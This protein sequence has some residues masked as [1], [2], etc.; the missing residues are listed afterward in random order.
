M[1]TSLLSLTPEEKIQRY[2]EL[3]AT[4]TSASY[5]AYEP[6]APVDASTEPAKQ[7]NFSSMIPPTM[8]VNALLHSTPI[9]KGTVEVKEEDSPLSI[10]N[11]FGSKSKPSMVPHKMVK[12]SPSLQGAMDYLTKDKGL[13]KHVAAGIVGN[14]YYESGLD[15]KIKQQNGGPGRGI[16]QWTDGDRWD[17]FKKWAKDAGRDPLDLQTQLDYVL[18]EPGWGD[19]AL[20]DTL[21]AKDAD[22]ATMI[23]GKSYERPKESKA[24]W[25]YRKRVANSLLVHQNY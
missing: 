9:P 3:T 14:L 17:G 24:N 1:Y 2:K 15:P 20:R 10:E 18:V 16:A 12:V 6:N 13:P 7:F 5:L 25:D 21:K 19:K 22:E 23:F 11:L 4:P 8:P